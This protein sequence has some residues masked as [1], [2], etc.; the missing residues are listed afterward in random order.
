MANME[1]YLVTNS[2]N[3]QGLNQLSEVGTIVLS[4]IYVLNQMS[5]STFVDKSTNGI[6]SN[7]KQKCSFFV[8]FKI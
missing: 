6:S 1:E 8:F 3:D 7:Y 5:I 4:F 2:Q